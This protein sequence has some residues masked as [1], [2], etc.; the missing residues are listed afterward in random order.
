MANFLNF[1]INIVA[2][3]TN[4][5]ATFTKVHQQLNVTQSA[6][7]SFNQNISNSFNKFN[8]MK[9]EAIAAMTERSG[10]AMQSL[11]APG[12]AFEQSMADLSAITGITG[13]ELDS[14]GD[15]ARKVGRQSGLGAAQAV[16]AYKVLASQIEVSKIGM[17]GLNMLQK[18]S[19][20]LAKASGMDIESA[21]L[22]LSG[23]IN[24]FGLE[25]SEA[26][27]VIN[28][29]AAGS[30][31]GAAEIP[32]LAQSF[33]VVGA[34][35]NAAG[36]SVESTAGALE[37]L[38]KNNLKGAEAGTALRNIMLKMQTTL[39][40]DF[41]KTS[42]TEALDA[43]KPKLNDATYLSKVFGIE[44][45]AA[46]QFLIANS[47]AVQEMTDK[48]TGSNVAQEQAAIRSQTMADR[49]AVI[50]ENVE[51]L[52]ISF[53]NLTGGAIGYI[54]VVGE[55]A[56]G[57]AN[58]I[59]LLEGLCSG[60]LYLTK[61]QNLQ[62]IWTGI[63]KVGTGAWAGVQNVLN[64]S[65]W[66]NPL[67]WIIASVIALV[68]V[69]IWVCSKITG[70]GSLWKGIIGFMKYGFLAFVEGIK[71]YWSTWIN[72]F[73]IGINYLLKGW[74][75][76]KNAMGLGDEN[77]NNAALAKIDADT[78]ARKKAIADGAQKV[79]DNTRKARESLG[80]IEMGWKK[81]E[82]EKKKSV[83]TGISPA[84]IPGTSG[85]V[86]I[87]TNQTTSPDVANQS[88]ESAVTGGT[89]G[90]NITIN[91][92]KFMDSVNIHAQEFRDGLNDLD[93]KVLES[94]TRVLTIAQSSVV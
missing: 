56:G 62:A 17:D 23:T 15:Q 63:V 74:Y 61:L 37:V 20:T 43:L 69:I 11:A 52:K 70:W 55:M 89:K 53:F 64:A 65:L 35:A 75:K 18:Q 60:I 66:A 28:I 88:S 25:A 24:Q 36:L 92:G 78:E 30:K 45:I 40:V 79:M 86:V 73:M 44:N 34:A 12:V 7:D 94:L 76:F 81:S 50:R 14:L 39:G 82:S 58:F 6:V 16:N 51:N 87:P 57:M 93:N 72:G 49:M 54:G 26:E 38:S 46:A 8:S 83:T 80:N 13:N 4:V 77:E 71:L 9:F 3:D 21:A 84:T 32:E 1:L 90:T 91:L 33:K 10:R 2:K 31:Y 59:P 42:M 41:K 67:T 19:I 5:H 22:S 29:L 85:A 47:N 27:R 68:G 48:V